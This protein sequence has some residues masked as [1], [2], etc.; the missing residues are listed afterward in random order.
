[1]GKYPDAYVV[2]PAKAG[3]HKMPACRQAG[4]PAYAGMTNTTP[5]IED[6]FLVAKMF[7]NFSDKFKIKK[8]L[9]MTADGFV[10]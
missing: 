10:L 9:H 5:L 8:P 3:I 2:I 6:Y 4:M 1:M 7:I